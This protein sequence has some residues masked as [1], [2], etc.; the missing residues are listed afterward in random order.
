[1]TELPLIFLGGLLG[2]SHCIG[3]CGPLALALGA[4]QSQLRTNLARQLVF[5]A[6]RIFTYSFGGAVAAF[7][8]WWLTQRPLA[9]IDCTSASA[10]FLNRLAGENRIVITATKS[11]AEQNETMFPRFFVA[12]L[13][14]A[15]A[16]TDK[17]GRVSLFEAFDYARQEVE[18]AYTSARRLQTEHPLLEADGDGVGTPAPTAAAGDG[19]AASLSFLGSAAGPSAGESPELRAL[20]VEKRRIEAALEALRL[21]RAQ[22]AEAEYQQQLEQLLLELSR[23]G[24]AIRRLSG[25]GS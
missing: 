24:Q 10:P 17:D 16:D 11:G 3:I 13:A 15:A 4:N 5:S 18:R 19:A 20:H 1:M 7:S 23:N 22:L 6:G 8:G 21:R 14:G 2:S 25:G 12:A 9:V